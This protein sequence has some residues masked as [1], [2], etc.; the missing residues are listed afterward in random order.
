MTAWLKPQK[1]VGTGGMARVMGILPGLPGTV[2]MYFIPTAANQA[3]PAT[4]VRMMIGY[5]GDSVGHILGEHYGGRADNPQGRAA[6][7][8]PNSGL[9]NVYP[10]HPT[11]TDNILNSLENM[12]DKLTKDASNRVC[13]R[14]TYFFNDAN[15]PY[16]PDEIQIEWWLNGALQPTGSPNSRVS[17]PPP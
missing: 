7:P 6:A 13:I 8:F 1:G 10:S 16:R 9:G 2:G 14:L 4:A 11:V 5:T 3:V 12:W 15:R 17:N